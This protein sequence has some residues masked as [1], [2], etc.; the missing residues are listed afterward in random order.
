MDCVFCKIRD[1]EIPGKFEYESDKV[2][3]FHDKSPAADVHILI[4]PK[5]HVATFLE[6][7]ENYGEVWIEILRVAQQLAKEKKVE[8]K[9]R[10]VI[11]GGSLQIVP[12]LHLHL[13]GGKWLKDNHD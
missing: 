3:A 7:G 13:L 2:M 11:N 6:L 10:L 4:V 5:V 12:H 1:K 9:Y 8:S